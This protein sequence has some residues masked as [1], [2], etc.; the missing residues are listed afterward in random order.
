VAFD[1]CVS[2]QPEAANPT[3]VI[4]RMPS[5]RVMTIMA[6]LPDGTYLIMGGAMSGVAG[7]GLATTP[8]LQAVLYDPSQP[9]HKR[10]SILGSTIVPRMYHSEATLLPDGRVLVSGS[11]PEDDVNPQEYR[12]EVYNPPYLSNGAIRPSFTL[13]NTD[14]NYGGQFQLTVVT[15]NMANTRVSLI[16]A[17]SSTHGNTFGQRTFFPA[18][19]RSGNTITVTAPPNAHVC[20]PGWYMVFVLDGPT[21]SSSRWVRIGGDPGAIGNWPNYPGFTLPGVGGL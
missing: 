12:L 18:V 3:W 1:N 19:T 13:T 2:I 7:F 5:K 11:D 21:P 8:N 15:T 4:E 16:G 6:A 10:F 20:P 17:S 14:W 9:R